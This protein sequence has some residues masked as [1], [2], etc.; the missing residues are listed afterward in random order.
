MPVGDRWRRRPGRTARAGIARFRTRSRSDRGRMRRSGI[1]EVVPGVGESIRQP[2]RQR[3]NAAPRSPG[4]RQAAPPSR[5]EPFGR[6]QRPLRVAR[7]MATR[8]NPTPAQTTRTTAS[9]S[10]PCLA[11]TA[12]PRLFWSASRCSAAA[13]VRAAPPPP[14][15]K[16]GSRSSRRGWRRE[17]DEQAR[18]RSRSRR[19]ERGCRRR[20]EP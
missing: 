4:R 8:I 3:S 6:G 18:P 11:A 10:S 19:L 17:Q 5:E 16:V 15:I 14:R 9:I 12:F 7:P 20:P 1:L 2:G 13:I